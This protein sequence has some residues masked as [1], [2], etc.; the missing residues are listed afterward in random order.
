[1]RDNL[2]HAEVFF[3]VFLVGTAVEHRTWLGA[4]AAIAVLLIGVMTVFRWF[5]KSDN[6]ATWL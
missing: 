5:L 3:G 4:G 6:T 1:M 2:C